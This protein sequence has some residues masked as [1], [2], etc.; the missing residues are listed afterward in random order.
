M[1]L[2][3]LIMISSASL[4]TVAEFTVNAKADLSVTPIN[5]APTINPELTALLD[6]GLEDTAYTIRQSDLLAGASDPDGDSLNAINLKV[7]EVK[8]KSSTTT[9]APGPSSQP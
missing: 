8:V 3:V 7:T 1:N 4:P 5:D 2:G 9:T 6:D